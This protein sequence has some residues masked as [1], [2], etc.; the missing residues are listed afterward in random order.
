MGPSTNDKFKYVPNV[1]ISLLQKKYKSIFLV[2]RLSK[3]SQFG[4]ISEISVT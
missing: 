4:I 2:V 3:R 1:F